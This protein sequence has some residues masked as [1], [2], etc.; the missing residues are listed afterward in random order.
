[1]TVSLG[2]TTRLV[3][4]VILGE[5]QGAVVA[6]A[7][8][9]CLSSRSSEAS[10]RRSVIARSLGSLLSFRIVI[11][12]KARSCYWCRCIFRPSSNRARLARSRAGSSD[13]SPTDPIIVHPMTSR[14]I[15]S[16]IQIIRL[17]ADLSIYFLII[18]R[19]PPRIP[20]PLPLCERAPPLRASLRLSTDSLPLGR[21]A[22]NPARPHT[23]DHHTVGRI[24]N[25]FFLVFFYFFIFGAKILLGHRV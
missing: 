23:P 1:M 2:Q 18:I 16:P 20:F 7:S 15:H 3:P 6:I 8:R 13:P 10:I 17:I 22:S 11:R 4:Y 5:N 25:F 21:R 12:A 14:I 19:F 24:F 9:W